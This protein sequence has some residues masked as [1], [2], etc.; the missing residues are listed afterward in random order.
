MLTIFQTAKASA[1]YAVFDMDTRDT[2]YALENLVYV[3]NNKA[4]S[5]V[6]LKVLI[7]RFVSGED[8][9]RT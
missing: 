8:L 7:G 9:N 5:V 4:P 2:I 6:E 3:E 1:K